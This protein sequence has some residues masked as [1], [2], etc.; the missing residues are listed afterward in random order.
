MRQSLNHLIARDVPVPVWPVF[1]L[2]ALTFLNA[3]DSGGC[4]GAAQAARD[5]EDT[6]RALFC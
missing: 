6:D 5:G 3:A 2:T 1:N 4:C